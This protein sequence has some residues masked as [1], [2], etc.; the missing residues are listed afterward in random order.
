MRSPQLLCAVL[1]VSLLAVPGA[2]RTYE[3]QADGFVI[4]DSGLIHGP[5]GNVTQL[6]ASAGPGGPAIDSYEAYTFEPNPPPSGSAEVEVHLEYSRPAV[7][8]DAPP[9]C[10]RTRDLDVRLL[11]GDGNVVDEA[12]DNCEEEPVLDLDAQ[13]DGATELTLEVFGGPTNLETTHYQLTI[14][15]DYV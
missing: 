14:D 7:D 2:A 12:V 8:L 1:V 5:Q 10:L 9:H 6:E 15:V 11:D 3:D 4:R 13:I